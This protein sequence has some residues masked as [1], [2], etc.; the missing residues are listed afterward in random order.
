[1]DDGERAD[2]ANA[3]LSKPDD[4]A[5]SGTDDTGLSKSALTAATFADCIK[6]N[7]AGKKRMSTPSDWKGLSDEAKEI[8]RRRIGASGSVSMSFG[9][10]ESATDA[11]EESASGKQA[12][13]PQ[14]SAPLPPTMPL[15]KPKKRKKTVPPKSGGEEESTALDSEPKKSPI[16]LTGEWNELPQEE[17]DRILGM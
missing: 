8:L 10:D 9:F 13:D 2:T 6:G 7:S 3:G 11:L 16:D 17:Q 15:P 5:S 14:S 1:V 12:E 4:G